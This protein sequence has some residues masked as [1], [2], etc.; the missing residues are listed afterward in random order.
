MAAAPH[1]GPALIAYDGSD[2][3]RAAIAA[4]GALLTAREAVV[5][6]TWS[7]IS[8][9]IATGVAQP[10]YVPDLEAAYRDQALAAASEGARLAEQAGL[11]ARPLV[12]PEPNG[13]WTAILDAADDIDASVVVV[14]ARGRSGVRS[15]LLG[16][17]SN[18][19]MHHSR[20]PVLVAHPTR[21]TRA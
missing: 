9:G 6:T 5:L 10:A 14:G 13:C 3:A 21:A 15:A 2:G 18:G 8:L 12:K 20:R 16:S 17:V 19:V 7:P 4:A 11:A 1:G